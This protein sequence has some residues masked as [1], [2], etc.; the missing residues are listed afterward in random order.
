[1]TRATVR[2]VL[3]SNL[4]ASRRVCGLLLLSSMLLCMSVAFSCVLC[5]MRDDQRL[6]LT[7]LVI[8]GDLEYVTESDVQLAFSKL[9]HIGT[10]MS[11]EPDILKKAV[12]DIPWVD[13]VAIRKQWPNI[14][15]VFL[16]EHK[17]LAIWN[18]DSILDEY[19]TIFSGD[20]R[21]ISKE[22]VKLYGPEDAIPEVLA[23]WKKY[24]PGFLAFHLH[25][26]SLVLSRRKAWKIALDNGIHL[27]LGSGH[28]N[29]KIARFFSLYDHLGERAKKI[30]SIDLRYNSGAAVSWS[31]N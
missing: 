8:R 27:E 15:E 3:Y 19:G 1:M 24:N 20:T 2:E 5:R 18:E 10:F 4:G 22:I 12:E 30:S 31:Q 14:V 6:S 17:A 28:I 9:D 21:A 7:R 16:T 13:H 29:E 23:A 11:Q 26:D 25:I